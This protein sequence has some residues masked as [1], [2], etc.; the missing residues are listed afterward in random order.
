VSAHPRPLLL[1]L[2]LL[3][4]DGG[5]G[6]TGGGGSDGGLPPAGGE[7][8]CTWETPDEDAVV[9]QTVRV[10]VTCR[11]PSGVAHLRFAADGATFGEVD[12]PAPG[13]VYALDWDSTSVEDGLHALE[14]TATA[15]DGRR[16]FVRRYVQTD[17]TP[18]TLEILAPLAGERF[19]GRIPITARPEDERG[20]AE[21]SATLG[22][23][24]VGRL[25]SPPSGEEVELVAD[26]G[27][28]VTGSHVLVVAAADEAGNVAA[29]S[30][31]VYVVTAPRFRVA[32]PQHLCV[33]GNPTDLALADEDGDG[34]LDLWFA[35]PQGVVLRRGRGDGTFE[36]AERLLEVSRTHLV[37][38]LD[39]DGDGEPELVRAGGSGG[40]AFLAVHDRKAGAWEDEEDETH[41]LAERAQVLAAAPV[42]GDSRPDLLVGGDRD[43]TSLGVLLARDPGE[44]EG[45][46]DA[47]RYSGGVTKVRSLAAGDIDGD[48]RTDVVV[49][50]QAKFF[51][52]FPGQGDGTFGIARDTGPDDG[53]KGWCLGVAL[54]DFQGD[55]ILDVLVT[56]YLS[57][58]FGLIFLYRG[59][60]PGDWQFVEDDRSFWTYT[61][62]GT[63]EVLVADVDLDGLDDALLVNHRAQN[64]GVY[65]GDGGGFEEQEGFAL[66]PDPQR[67]RLGDLDEDGLL[68]LVCLN[69]SPG[70]FV[71]L[72]GRPGGSFSGAPTLRVVRPPV[73]LVV[74]HLDERTGPDLAVVSQAYAAAE[75]RWFD[76]EIASSDGAFP[77]HPARSVEVEVLG[78][79]SPR[80]ARVGKLTG[81]AHED[82][83]VV[84]QTGCSS[85]DDCKP[86]V[87]VLAGDGQGG[88]GEHQA[89]PL[90]HRPTTVTLCDLNAD[91][92]TDVVVGQPDAAALPAALVLGRASGGD[93]LA[94]EPMT[95]HRLSGDPAD[96]ACAL[97][98]D[99]PVWDLV[100][101][102]TRDGSLNVFHG[103][104][105]PPYV[106]GE[107][108]VLALGEQPRRLVIADVD[109]DG[110]RDVVA[111][112]RDN[113]AVAFGSPGGETFD[114]ATFLSHS[115]RSPWGVAV[116][117]F[118]DDA[119]PDVA[120]ANQ[121]GATV[122]VYANAGDRT[123][124]GP[125]DLHTGPGPSELVTADFNG[126]GC[127]DLASLNV[128]SRTITLLLAEGPRCEQTP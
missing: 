6:E 33:H 19:V 123:F 57:D 109:G 104:T 28:V 27:G 96:L 55:G 53:V 31:E 13:D 18:P 116:R 118:T 5:P 60:G 43:E 72:L 113:L 3:A 92:R 78:Q 14:A 115:G 119:L 30:V 40:G 86:S 82:L 45:W 90:G 75:S 36:A 2:P 81:D 98:G 122:S 54:A 52:V 79:G 67:A 32:S 87:N 99:D 59:G 95:Q 128:T 58:D 74:G 68:D 111:S 106:V 66:G 108:Q 91:G 15:A 20:L 39:L 47:P 97:L 22:E 83:V 120:V 34:H 21:L 25:P 101:V 112:V 94:L 16:G 89:F 65:L 44:A 29:A 49:G 125:L 100:S 93:S 64:L 23:E 88:L 4:C 12:G 84:T 69:G 124:V 117:D 37:L 56:Q 46:F 105:S 127:A 50:R 42:D 107:R 11:H 77:R 80:D 103:A 71:V 114:T 7:V 51:S 85:T 38:P 17:N 48:G 121:T 41:A 63:S 110:Q 24:T 102:N 35:T 70:T 10:A 61:A 62:P 1:A 76:V 126:D 26:V 8:G 9:G 73:D